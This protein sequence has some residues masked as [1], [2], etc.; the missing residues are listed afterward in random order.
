M[1]LRDL[2][3]QQQQQ[4]QQ[5][6]DTDSCYYQGRSDSPAAPDPQ[7]P[8]AATWNGRLHEDAFWDGLLDNLLNIHMGLS[9]A[10]PPPAG[11]QAAAASQQQ[12]Q[13]QPSALG[14]TAGAAAAAAAGL[15]NA[16]F[17][18]FSSGTQQ[19]QLLQQQQQEQQ[20]RYNAGGAAAAVAVA[21][22]AIGAAM[23]AGTRASYNKS[24][25]S[26]TGAGMGAAS[27][28]LLG[29]DAV[30]LQ[31]QQQQQSMPATAAA[32][33]TPSYAGR[34]QGSQQASWQLTSSWR[35]C[36]PGHHSFFKAL[37]ATGGVIH[38]PNGP[39]IPLNVDFEQEIQPHLAGLLGKGGFG[40][41]YEGFWR[42]QKVRRAG[43][44]GDREPSWFIAALPVKFSS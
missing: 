29:S 28:G 26:A 20:Q 32:A 22:E 3:Q 2:Q 44:A 12:Q 35:T 6:H 30:T 37:M 5:Q 21:L 14:R 43:G 23:H 41:V 42:G 9:P 24:S 34:G 18:S 19:Q 4:K 25:S 15:S 38:P 27:N 17:A 16:G 33:P 11:L 1:Q 8:R 31:Q 10:G 7:S 36:Q 40:H 13:Q 39:A